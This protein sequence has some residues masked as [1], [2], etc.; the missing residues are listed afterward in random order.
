MDDYE[1]QATLKQAGHNNK[2]KKACLDNEEHINQLHSGEYTD[3]V[4]YQ[5]MKAHKKADELLASLEAGLKWNLT[6]SYDT[7]KLMRQCGLELSVQELYRADASPNYFDLVPLKKESN[8]MRKTSTKAVENRPLLEQARFVSAL[9]QACEAIDQVEAWIKA[10]QLDATAIAHIPDTILPKIKECIAFIKVDDALKTTDDALTQQND[11]VRR[12]KEMQHKALQDGE[13]ILVEEASYTIIATLERIMELIGDKFAVINNK[14]EEMDNF[15]DI[16]DLL[17]E[18]N[19]RTFALKQEKRRLK[20]RCE[21]DLHN[22]HEAIARYDREDV[23]ALKDF[24]LFRT[25]S[26]TKLQE[27]VANQEILWADMVKNKYTTRLQDIIADLRQTGHQRYDMMTERIDRIDKEELRKVEY[28]QFLEV[29]A[30]HKKTLELTI[31]NCETAVTCIGKFEQLCSVLA[32]ALRDWHDA[33]RDELYTLRL[34]VHKEHLGYFRELYL[35]IGNLLHKKE[36]IVEDTDKQLRS[37]HIQLEFCIETFDMEAKKHSDAKKDL[38]KL[39]TETEEEI[40][41]LRSK[42]EQAL[43]E[44][45][46]TDDAL[47]EAGFEFVHPVVEFQELALQQRE[48]IVA[49]KAQF[50]KEDD[51]R[52]A[53][54]REEI[55]RQLAISP[56]RNLRLQGSPVKMLLP[57]R[58]NS[59]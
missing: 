11:I 14:E 15:K 30:H 57:R 42:A 17:K 59:P 7:T 48:K 33:V 55:R 39:R 40:E 56:S 50:N 2:L 10:S 27:N 12:T 8:A 26:D 52:I 41:M 5:L 37:E 1:L 21:T 25:T 47:R 20:Q 29:V 24:S 38:I 43:E 34:N 19:K 31:L 44:F 54:E 22:V 16:F 13:M 4:H 53:A 51:V 46:E 18:S 58:G 23:A 45:G 9:Q 6:T 36:K 49:Y 3:S 32:T 28:H 35:C